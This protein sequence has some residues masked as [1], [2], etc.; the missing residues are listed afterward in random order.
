MSASPSQFRNMAKLPLGHLAKASHSSLY[1]SRVLRSADQNTCQNCRPM[2]YGISHRHL[3]LFNQHLWAGPLY[4]SKL[5]SLFT[6]GSTSMPP[7]MALSNHQMPS[8]IWTPSIASTKLQLLSQRFRTRPSPTAG[9]LVSPL[10]VMGFLAPMCIYCGCC[11]P[12][13]K[14]QKQNRN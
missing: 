6:T 3:S 12:G 13:H 8:L 10:M 11:A 9:C 7:L 4:A 5:G 14:K 1:S 2:R